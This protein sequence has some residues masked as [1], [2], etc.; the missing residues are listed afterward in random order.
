MIDL[1]VVAGFV[2]DVVAGSLEVIDVEVGAGFVG[3]IVV[4]VAIIP[5]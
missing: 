4:E 5:P 3:L 2:V 1:E